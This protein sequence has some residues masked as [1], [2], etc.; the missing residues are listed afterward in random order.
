M[1]LHHSSVSGHAVAAA[2][3]GKEEGW[4]QVIAQRESSTAKNPKSQKAITFMK[5]SLMSFYAYKNVNVR[6][7]IILFDLGI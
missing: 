4:Q 5:V 2:H 1:G 6:K 7:F 3:I